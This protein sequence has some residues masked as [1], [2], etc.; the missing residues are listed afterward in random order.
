MTVRNVKG[1]QIQ[2]A[3]AEKACGKRVERVSYY[4]EQGKPAKS[5]TVLKSQDFKLRAVQVTKKHQ[6]V[7]LA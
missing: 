3:G 7:A 2:F 1:S 6:E 4:D 5:N